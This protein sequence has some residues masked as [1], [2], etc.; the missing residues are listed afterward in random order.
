MLKGDR[1]LPWIDSHAH[2]TMFAA[3]EVEQTIEAAALAGVAGV[4]VPATNP[5]DLESSLRLARDYR[6]RVVAA[7][8]VHPHD[9]VRLDSGMKRVLEEALNNVGVV[10]VGEIGLDYHYMNSPRE[11][12]ISALEW[13]LDLAIPQIF[14]W[15]CTTASPGP[16][17]SLGWLIVVG[18]CA[19]CA[20][21]SRKVPRRL[22][23]LWIWVC[24]WEFPAW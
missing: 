6:G 3:E 18:A 5:D 16:I 24:W 20:T 4:L 13:Q 15:F 2:L 22:G 21:H 12:Q 17:S 11:D 10:A 23:G 8:G 9:A 14:R 7:A 1:D 19:A